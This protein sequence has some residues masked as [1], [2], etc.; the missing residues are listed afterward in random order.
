[1]PD[2]SLP[3]ADAGENVPERPFIIRGLRRMKEPRWPLVKRLR[4]ELC[5][6]VVVSGK[7]LRPQDLLETLEVLEYESQ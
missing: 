5:D 4:N 1:M 6:E 3:S 2:H 7:R